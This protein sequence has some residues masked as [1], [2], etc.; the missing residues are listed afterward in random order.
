MQNQVHSSRRKKKNLGLRCRRGYMPTGRSYRAQW[1]W[2][3]LSG[4]H[5]RFIILMG[6]SKVN[7]CKLLGFIA[8][9]IWR[10]LFCAKFVSCCLLCCI[11]N[12]GVFLITVCTEI[13]DASCLS[14]SLFAFWTCLCDLWL[15]LSLLTW[16]F[17][18][19]LLLS[20]VKEVCFKTLTSQTF[21]LIAWK[22]F[23]SS[24]HWTSIWSCY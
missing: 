10:N 21:K 7:I 15:Q 19:Q 24:N 9:L 11:K 12:I 22:S 3:M 20:V 16:T 23:F 6:F 13:W 1:F 2:E 18:L 5:S 4:L 8:T 14:I 17:Q